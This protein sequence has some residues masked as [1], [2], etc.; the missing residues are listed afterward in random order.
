MLPG[1]WQS[2]DAIGHSERV[3][4][5]NHKKFAWLNS[6]KTFGNN[7]FWI[8]RKINERSQITVNSIDT[9]VS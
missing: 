1:K 9:I 4:L 8:Q 2:W 3:P 5:N 7:Y 6:L